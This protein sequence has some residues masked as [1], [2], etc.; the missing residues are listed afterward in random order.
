MEE[1]LVDL[2]HDFLPKKPNVVYHIVSAE[3][4]KNWKAYVKM[5]ESNSNTGE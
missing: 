3:W 4:Y 1:K 2:K 5:S